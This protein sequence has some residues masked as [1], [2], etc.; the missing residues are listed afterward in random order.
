MRRKKKQPDLFCEKYKGLNSYST[1]I[2]KQ[3]MNG[4][5]KMYIWIFEMWLGSCGNSEKNLNEFGKP[6]KLIIEMSYP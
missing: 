1:I 6:W 3:T 4:R 2:K 5:N